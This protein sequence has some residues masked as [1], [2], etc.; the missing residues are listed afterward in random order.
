[1]YVARQTQT[2][3]LRNIQTINDSI[4]QTAKELEK[5]QNL[6]QYILF[7]LFKSL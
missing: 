4:L 5:I 6:S 7:H 2:T 3:Y 1:M